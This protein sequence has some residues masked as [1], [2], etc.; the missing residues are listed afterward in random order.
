MP[1]QSVLL[2]RRKGFSLEDAKKKIKELKFKV[3]KV[4]ITKKHFRFR[5]EP[6]RKFK[7]FRS[8]KVDKDLTFVFGFK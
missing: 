2:K 4:D 7:R 1:I 6:P 8:K 5:Q 3:L